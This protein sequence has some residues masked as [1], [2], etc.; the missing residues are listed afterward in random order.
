MSVIPYHRTIFSVVSAADAFHFR[1]Q[2]DSQASPS[3]SSC[4]TM[5]N[6]E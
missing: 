3:Q 5:Q 4:L 6:S 2:A 1:L